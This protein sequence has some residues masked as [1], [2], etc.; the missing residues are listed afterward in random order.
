MPER[1]ASATRRAESVPRASAP[2]RVSVLL[3]LPLDRAYD[4]AVPEGLDLAPGD[5]VRVP[6][7]ARAL[8]GVVW[9]PDA[10][11]RHC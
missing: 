11:L 7:G 10:R 1:R 6:L 2:A 4:Y 9:E 8:A 5:L 3:P